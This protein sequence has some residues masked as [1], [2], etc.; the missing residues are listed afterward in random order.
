M[1]TNSNS[2]EPGSVAFR[3][4]LDRMRRAKW[5][6]DVAARD[7][8]FIRVLAHRFTSKAVWVEFRSK[9]PRCNVKFTNGGPCAPDLA[10]S[11]DMREILRYQWQDAL[12]EHVCL[13]KEAMGV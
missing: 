8:M 5:A 4:V 10:Y 7:P 9:C 1:S 2:F 11:V 12:T 6:E 13:R 3:H